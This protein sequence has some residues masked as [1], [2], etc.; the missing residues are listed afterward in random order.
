MP[1][2]GGGIGFGPLSLS[3]QAMFVGLVSNLIVFPSTILI[4]Q[5]FKK[6]RPRKLKPSRVDEALEKQREGMRN[7]S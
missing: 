3:P 7:F 5:F 1:A 4:V 2:S 6:A